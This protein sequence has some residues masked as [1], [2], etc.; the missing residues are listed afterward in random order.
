MW[1]R[2][3]VSDARDAAMRQAMP[4]TATPEELEATMLA[5]LAERGPGKTIGP[6]DVA[7]LS[8][9]TSR[10]DGGRSCSPFGKWRCA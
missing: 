5:L 2:Q 9:A 6:A 7:Q 4:K 8:A 10:T 3:F 1:R